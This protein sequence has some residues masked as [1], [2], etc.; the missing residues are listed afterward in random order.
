[1]LK[2]IAIIGVLFCLCAC[3]DEPVKPAEAPVPDEMKRFLA[4]QGI[5]PGVEL[6]AAVRFI[7]YH[8]VNISVSGTQPLLKGNVPDTLKLSKDGQL[9]GVLR[10]PAGS[11]QFSVGENEY[12]LHVLEQPHALPDVPVACDYACAC[13]LEGK[14]YLFG[15][16]A[17]IADFTGYAHRYDTATRKWEELPSMPR[18][19]QRASAAALEGRIYVIGGYS[20]EESALVAVFDPRKKEWSEGPPVAQARYA[21]CA[22]VAGTKI[23]Y[24]GGW[25]QCRSALGCSSAGEPTTAVEILDG[26]SGKWEKGESLPTARGYA[27]CAAIG[28]K[29]YVAGGLGEYGEFKTLEIY[30]MESGKWSKGLDM[31]AP[32]A[33]CAG[34]ELGGR[35]FVFGGA[36]GDNYLNEV[37]S[38]DPASGKWRKERSL[39][40]AREALVAAELGGRAYLLGGR[41]SGLYLPACELYGPATQGPGRGH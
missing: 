41:V 16:R 9:L 30:D 27:A 23:Y 1:M 8:R 10:S 15:G 22:A 29:I 4:E 33:F 26:K 13:T 24:I 34:C 12:L 14:V 39:D 5:L 28:G 21:G 32:V 17:D 7:P 18:P 35:L 38:Y 25:M 20:G 11:Y 31:P 3:S 19:K 40:F 2:H 36:R 37:V 6:P